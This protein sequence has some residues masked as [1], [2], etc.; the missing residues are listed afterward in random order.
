MKKTDEERFWAKVGNRSEPSACWPWLG[1]TCGTD[2]LRYGVFSIRHRTVL[3]HR[4]SYE[5][6]FGLIPVGM[7]LDHVKARG[8]VTTLCVNPAHLEVVTRW[9]N[10]LRGNGPLATNARKT[11]CMRGH[12]FNLENTYVR[13]DHG[14]GVRNCRVCHRERQRRKLAKCELIP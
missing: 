11:H 9:E 14:N 5:L 4:F 6:R 12:P 1:G 2:K 8:C 13:C 7:T 10:V 3:A